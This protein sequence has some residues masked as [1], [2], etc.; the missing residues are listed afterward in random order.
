MINYNTPSGMGI[1][2]ATI[3]L[4]ASIPSNTEPFVSCR[5]SEMQISAT[6]ETNLD[7]YSY[8]KKNMKSVPL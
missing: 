8:D 4:T 2:T 7:N 1:Y 3:L 5:Y 6:Y